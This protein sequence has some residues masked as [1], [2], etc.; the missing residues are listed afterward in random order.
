MLSTCESKNSLFLLFNKFFLLTFIDFIMYQ[1]VPFLNGAYF[2]YS[3]YFAGAVCGGFLVLGSLLIFIAWLLNK[4]LINSSSQP[5]IGSKQQVQQQNDDFLLSETPLNILTDSD[6]SSIMRKENFDLI[7]SVTIYI[8]WAG[9]FLLSMMPVSLSLFDVLI[10]PLIG[11]ILM[12]GILCCRL[13]SRYF[14]NVLCLN[15]KFQQDKISAQVCFK[16]KASINSSYRR[17]LILLFIISISVSFSL[18][19]GCIAF[20]E[21][22]V[23]LNILNLLSFSTTLMRYF[24]LNDACP[25]GPPCHVYATLPEE[26]STG[27]FINVH[28]SDIYENVTILYDIKS[29]YEKN[30]TLRYSEIANSYKLSHLEQRGRRTVHSALLYKLF[31][32]TR[33]V[34]AIKYANEIQ[35]LTEYETLPDE[36]NSRNFI[37]STGGDMGDRSVGRDLTKQAASVGPDIMAIGGDLSYDDGEP[38]CYFTWDNMLRSFAQSTLTAGRLVPFLFSIGNHD[39]GL[40]PLSNRDLKIDLEGPLYMIF[41][42]QHTVK[43]TNNEQKQINKV[44]DINER[45]SY[46]YHTFGKILFYN[47]DTGYLTYFAEQARFISTIAEKYPNYIKMV[48]HHSPIYWGCTSSNH[49]ESQE[50]LEKWIPLFDK[51]KF[52]GIFENHEHCLKK[53]FPLKGNKIHKDGAYYLGNGKWG[54]TLSDKCQPNN[55]T[56]L[57]EIAKDVNHFWLVNISYVEDAVR[58]SAFDPEGYQVVPTFS[59]NIH[60]YVIN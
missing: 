29:H 16:K 4:L 59:Q 45:K 31:P 3:E 58:Y 46:H 7:A 49:K 41:F 50:A 27:V 56:G 10:S 1:W 39:V 8:N 36:T 14:S 48:S 42:P 47:L 18:T 44:P 15:K 2:T 12:F 51:Y 37:I 23:G 24:Q 5:S 21:D 11:A 43:D 53:T 13:T 28:T 22:Y 20:Y 26:A 6:S 33:Y 25:P 30:Q 60:K 32:S 34:I 40:N 57:L 35:A 52:M 54:V 17:N 19:G 9:W 38:T 55:E